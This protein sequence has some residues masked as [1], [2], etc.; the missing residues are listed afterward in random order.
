MSEVNDET[1]RVERRDSTGQYPVQSKRADEQETSNSLHR[2]GFQI[3][4]INPKTIV[5]WGMLIFVGGTAISSITFYK[6]LGAEIHT[7]IHNDLELHDTLVGFKHE[8]EDVN[9][10]LKDHDQKFIDL[11]DYFKPKGKK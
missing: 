4:T 10:T 2:N 7:G 5:S 11:K 8:F 1:S 6:R 3:F 9:K